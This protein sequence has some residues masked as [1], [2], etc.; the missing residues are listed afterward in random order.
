M[1][2]NLWNT[3]PALKNMHPLKIQVMN[4]LA[5]NTSG[6]SLSQSIPYLVKAQQTLNSSGL[7][8]SPEE[9]TL[10]MEILTKDMTS[11]E[12]QQVERIRMLLNQQKRK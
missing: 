3:H 11:E 2:Q 10:L 6:K 7:S 9:S 1:N 8:F 12:K 4:E 5:E